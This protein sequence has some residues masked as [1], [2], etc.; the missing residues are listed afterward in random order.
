MGSPS[1]GSRLGTQFGSY[2]LQEL[3]LRMH[4][5]RATEWQGR[6]PGI[7]RVLADL[8]ALRVPDQSPTV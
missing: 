6:R 4:G 8:P 5:H 2:E 1:V 7:G 3:L